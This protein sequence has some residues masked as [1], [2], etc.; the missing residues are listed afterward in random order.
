MKIAWTTRLIWILVFLFSIFAPIIYGIIANKKLLFYVFSIPFSFLIA[1]VFS[2]FITQKWRI[3]AFSNVDNIF[4]LRKYAEEDRFIPEGNLLFEKSEYNSKWYKTK[5]IELQK[6]FNEE[7]VHKL[8]YAIPEKV[9]IKT[10]YFKYIFSSH[11][12]VFIFFGPIYI[13]ILIGQNSNATT[14]MLSICIAFLLLVNAK[15][16]KIL[17]S[18]NSLII[19]NECF[20]VDNLDIYYWNKIK[21]EEVIPYYIGRQRIQA[22][23][24]DY[25]QE[26]VIIQLLK[27][28][29]NKYKLMNIIKTIRL[30]TNLN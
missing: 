29:I 20:I 9:V 8:D 22:L 11:L 14:F 26:V 2:F 23:R 15:E 21:N 5:W 24:F 1:Y 12:S 4:E 3:W 19:D 10:G 25:E 6:R 16:I 13:G 28:K 17:F 27:Y 18:K 30:R 7:F